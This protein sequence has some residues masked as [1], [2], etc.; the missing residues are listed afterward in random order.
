[1]LTRSAIL[2][3]AGLLSI[4]CGGGS[5]ITAPPQEFQ[6]SV[7]GQGSGTGRI[8]ATSSSNGFACSVGV[9]VSPC[10]SSFAEGTQL[11][12]QATPSAQSVFDAWHV[13]AEGCGTQA[14]CT[15]TVSR[16]LSVQATFATT[17]A[18]VIVVSGSSGGSLAHTAFTVQLR[19]T[20]GP[21]VYKIEVWG[22]PHS[23]NGP[24]FFFGT[25]EPVEVPTGY[26]E[27]VLY[28]LSGPLQG[29]LGWVLVFTRDQGSAVYRQT[30]RFD[31]PS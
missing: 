7:S 16:E 19:N 11:T 20:G 18:N 17:T 25:T 13:D 2:V 23:P 9:G 14:T 10:Q 22:L 3:L 29:P 12:F 8:V 28:E 6:V 21:G 24:D 4:G 31:F 27:T 1:V 5:G 30:A 15:L 26:E